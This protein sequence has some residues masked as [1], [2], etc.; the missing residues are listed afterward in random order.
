VHVGLAQLEPKV[1]VMC[2]MYIGPRTFPVQL[3]SP[4]GA[5]E[6]IDLAT[7]KRIGP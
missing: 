7:G 4:V 1:G 2:P 6:V 3:S 5:R